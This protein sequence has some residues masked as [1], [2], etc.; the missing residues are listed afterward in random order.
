ML[1]LGIAILFS[2]CTL[3]EPAP[4]DVV[5]AR[6][7]NT[8]LYRADL[9]GLVPPGM[10]PADSAGMIK[11]YVDNWIRQQVFLK[12]ATSNLPPEKMD[13]ER[14]IQDYE[15]SLII[16]TYETELVR[17]QLDNAV[18]EA[19]IRD[20]YEEHKNTLSLRENIVKAIYIKVPLDAPDLGQL[21]RLYRSTDEEQMDQ[22]E[23]YCLDH[24]AS[25]Y[26]D[27]NIWMLFTEI[28]KDAP[29]NTSDPE[30]WL[31]NNR[32]AELKDDYYRYFIHI[33]E[34]KEKGD[35]PPLAFEREN[36]RSLLLNQRKHTFINEQRSLFFQEAMQNGDFEVFF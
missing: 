25:Y 14:T 16:Y 32:S 21:R 24:A 23:S 11:R 35:V 3:F 34:Y 1:F 6:A 18:S 29:I 4:E 19:Q 20:Y 7:Y 9:D 33:E 31:R 8:Y 10:S 15:N 30:S 17:N 13:F 28:M 27:T 2:A 5:V 22:L 26:L 36:I 12:Q